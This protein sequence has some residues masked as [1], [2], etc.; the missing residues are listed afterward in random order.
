M[1]LG[2]VDTS[3]NLRNS[4]LPATSL[5]PEIVRTIPIVACYRKFNQVYSILPIYYH[6]YSIYAS[7]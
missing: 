1:S 7:L 3:V 2:A 6:R 5:L 4:E